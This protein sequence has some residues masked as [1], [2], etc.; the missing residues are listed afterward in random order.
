MFG[1]LLLA[2][3][4]ALASGCGSKP[5]ATV[6][7]E[8]EDKVRIRKEGFK[9]LGSHYKTVGDA[10][11]KGQPL[12]GDATIQFS[13]QQIATYAAEQQAWFDPGTGP[14]SGVETDAMAE[15]W[16]DRAQFDRKVEAFVAAANK[17][18]QD[19]GQ[20]DDAAFATQFQAVGET[21][22]DCHKT[23]RTEERD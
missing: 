8:V 5:S 19:F 7:P 14:E 11:K 2:S 15:I 4:A 6:D 21:C 16:T 12:Q 9:E 20:G 10:L 17:L 13:V 3:L 18:V 23:Y 1:S 22:Q